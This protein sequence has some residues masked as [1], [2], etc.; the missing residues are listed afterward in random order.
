MFKILEAV[1]GQQEGFVF[2]T[3]KKEGGLEGEALF[4]PCRRG[5]NKRLPSLT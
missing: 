2:L 5:K 1:W 3:V 4:L